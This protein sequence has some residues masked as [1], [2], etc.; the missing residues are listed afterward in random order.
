MTIIT[1]KKF[2]VLHSVNTCCTA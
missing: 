1:T 2:K